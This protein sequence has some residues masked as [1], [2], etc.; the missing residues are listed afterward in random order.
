LRLY[1]QMPNKRLI[2]M[3]NSN[4]FSED[5][6]FLAMLGLESESWHASN[7]VG[8]TFTGGPGSI[9][10]GFTF[11]FSTAMDYIDE[12]KLSSTNPAIPALL[13][14]RDGE[15]MIA[16][17]QNNVGVSSKVFFAGFTLENVQLNLQD[18]FIAKLMT[19]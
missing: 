14:T 7:T 17:V 15:P 16:A 18:D 13:T 1:A 6:A 11:D 8:S 19:L 2:V 12:L 3:G 5:N 9:M 4:L 10:Q